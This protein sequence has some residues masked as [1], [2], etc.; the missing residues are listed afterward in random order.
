MDGQPNRASSDPA[1]NL[2]MRCI[3]T[4]ELAVRLQRLSSRLILLRQ[5]GQARKYGL[6]TSR[7]E[8]PVASLAHQSWSRRRALEVL[9]RPQ[10]SRFPQVARGFHLPAQSNRREARATR[11]VAAQRE[12]IPAAIP[13]PGQRFAPHGK[14]FPRTRD[15]DTF[16]SREPPA[17]NRAARGETSPLT[18]KNNSLPEFP[19]AAGVRGKISSPAKAWPAG[20]HQCRRTRCSCRLRRGFSSANPDRFPSKKFP[21]FQDYRQ[22][23]Q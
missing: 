1:K 20:F 7:R 23:A 11:H 6:S 21:A 9:A 19:L 5:T 14:E 13:A 10:I 3:G 22:P 16:C 17:G 15:A 8:S 12:R 2:H 18:K 4:A